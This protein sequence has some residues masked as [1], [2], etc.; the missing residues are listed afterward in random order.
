MLKRR[1]LRVL[2]EPAEGDE[3]LAAKRENKT[4]ECDLT[5][6]EEPQWRAVKQEAIDV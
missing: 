2:Q 1:T 5:A 3:V 4:L 6:D